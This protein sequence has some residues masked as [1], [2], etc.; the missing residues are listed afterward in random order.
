[1][2][3]DVSVGVLVLFVSETMLYNPTRPKV[4]SE[5]LCAGKSD[6]G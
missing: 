4:K 5:R 3:F 2:W 1:M 6:G